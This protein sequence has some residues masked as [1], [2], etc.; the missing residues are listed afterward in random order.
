MKQDSS[1]GLGFLILSY[2]KGEGNPEALFLVKKPSHVFVY[3]RKEDVFLNITS[4]TADAS[5]GQTNQNYRLLGTVGYNSQDII[6]TIFQN[7]GI[8]KDSFI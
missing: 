4:R 3:F 6:I 7:S 1:K 8:F 2:I 5:A